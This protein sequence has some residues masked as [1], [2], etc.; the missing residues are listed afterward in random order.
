MSDFIIV[1]CPSCEGSIIVFQNEINCAIFRHGVYVKS[2]K[3]I[4]PHLPKEQCDTLVNEKK[5]IG[6]G[7]PFRVVDGKAVACDYI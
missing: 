3:Q 7:K 6:C 1:S 5:I 4:D 2:F